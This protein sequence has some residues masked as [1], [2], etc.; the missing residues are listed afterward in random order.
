MM[1][2]ITT[3]LPSQRHREDTAMWCRPRQRISADLTSIH[4]ILM[5]HEVLSP[6]RRCEHHAALVCGPAHRPSKTWHILSA[7]SPT[8][9][10][11]AA[12]PG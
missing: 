5:I 1:I 6:P 11:E 2:I 4:L 3:P 9:V 12:G 8:Y 7:S 10:V